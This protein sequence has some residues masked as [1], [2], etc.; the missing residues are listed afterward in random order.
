M[1]YDQL[2]DSPIFHISNNGGNEPL[3]ENTKITCGISPGQ[4]LFGDIGEFSK[5]STNVPQAPQTLFFAKRSLH[6]R[7]T[8]SVFSERSPESLKCSNSP[9]LICGPDIW[10]QNPQ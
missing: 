10:T 6:I 2:D 9:Q 4:R 8:F 3:T 7:Q 5:Y 1:S